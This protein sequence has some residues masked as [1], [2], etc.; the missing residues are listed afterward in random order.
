[1]FFQRPLFIR[2]RLSD[3]WRIGSSH[4]FLKALLKFSILFIR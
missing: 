3:A 4:A 1:M 2:A